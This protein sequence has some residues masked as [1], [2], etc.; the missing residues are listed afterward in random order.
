MNYYTISENDLCRLLANSYEMD[1]I[2]DYSMDDWDGAQEAREDLYQAYWKCLHPNKNDCPN[3]YNFREIANDV[4]K[5]GRYGAPIE[6][7]AYAI[8]EK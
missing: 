2:R 4:I 1:F 5:E 8:L 3:S 6:R 7:I